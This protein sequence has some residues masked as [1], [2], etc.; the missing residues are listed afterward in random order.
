MKPAIK[1]GLLNGAIAILWSLLMYIT[2]LNRTSAGQWINIV[3]MAIPI[4]FMTMA[5]K[6]YRSGVGNGWIS[7]G[8]SFR[9]AFTVGVIGGFIGVGFYFIYLTFIDP[10]FIDYQKQLQVDKWTE[11]GMSEEMIQSYSE[12]SAQFMTPGM[13][14]IFGLVF[15]L[16]IASVLSLIVAAIMKKPN[17]EEIV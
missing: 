11:S 7:F 2:G 14:F 5:I 10:G 16:F 4:V 3:S 8:K 13:Q 12:K 1:Y 17:P 6:D 15:M 9:Q